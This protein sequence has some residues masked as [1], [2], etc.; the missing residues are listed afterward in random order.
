MAGFARDPIA[1]AGAGR[2]AQALGRLLADRGEPVAAIGG[3]NPERTAAAAAFLGH[4]VRPLTITAL[5]AAAARIL[6]AVSDA[7]IPEV[8]RLLAGAGMRS[9]AALHT[10]GVMG[11]EA[12]A[13]LAEAGVCCGA[14][15]PL[16]TFATPEDGLLALP[17]SAFAID[18]GPAALA[19]AR[20]IAQIAGGE[21][22]CIPASARA[23][24]HA[25]SVMASNYVAALL[26]AAAILMKEAGAQ[27]RQQAL[28][29]IG[30]PALASVRNVLHLGTAEALTGPIQRGDAETVRAHLAALAGAPVRI[31]ELYREAGRYTLEMA[32]RGG[33]DAEAAEQ[34][35]LA[36]EKG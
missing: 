23:L 10:C 27:S 31:R 17:G 9:G 7:A 33:L 30:R 18:G 3:R 6:I 11:A 2:V 21:A 26:D 15:H 5:P 25:A 35:A 8:A 24:Y 29:A 12:L 4:G 16:Q 22:I 19:W 14:I 32:I 20:R 34:I 13:P 28:T 1:I 36:L